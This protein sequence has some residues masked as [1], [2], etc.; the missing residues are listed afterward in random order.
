[1]DV[2][3]EVAML[4]KPR[5]NILEALLRDMQGKAAEKLVLFKKL[6]AAGGIAEEHPADLAKAEKMPREFAAMEMN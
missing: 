2:Q 6:R 4:W 5:R 1:M 3:R